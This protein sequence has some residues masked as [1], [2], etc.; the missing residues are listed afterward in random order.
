VTLFY[1]AGLS[2]TEVAEHLGTAVGA[3]KTRLHKARA[4]LQ[5]RLSDLRK[6]PMPVP[7]VPMRVADVRDTGRNEFLS[8]HVIFLEEQDGPRRLPIWVGAAEATTLALR[9]R[10]VELPRPGTYELTGDLLR[11]AGAHLREVRIVAL[12]GL[13]S[14]QASCSATRLAGETKIRAQEPRAQDSP[15]LGRAGTRRR[16]EPARLELEQR[17]RES[18]PVARKEQ[19][20]QDCSSVLEAKTSVRAQ[21]AP[22]SDD[23]RKCRPALLSLL[24]R[25]RERKRPPSGFASAPVGD[26]PQRDPRARPSP[27]P[28][29]D[30]RGVAR[31]PYVDAMPVHVGPFVRMAAR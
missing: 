24:L 12:T 20:D 8:S 2:Q 19:S 9:L 1:L 31:R 26:E 14:P 11:A 16:R 3:V 21:V 23:T 27:P 30:C 5:D 7:T 29:A 28:R 17:S 13:T 6:E 15:A 25:Q 22:A 18:E 4:S 10:E